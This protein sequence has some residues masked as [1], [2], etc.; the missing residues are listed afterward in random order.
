MTMMML[1][2]ASATALSAGPD[3]LEV[4]DKTYN[5]DPR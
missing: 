2:S 1:N 4:R 3:I 5:E